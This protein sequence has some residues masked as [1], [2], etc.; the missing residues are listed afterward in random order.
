MSYGFSVRK[1]RE[2]TL[3]LVDHNNDNFAQVAKHIPDGALFSIHGHTPAVGNSPVGMIGV[4]LSVPADES[5]EAMREFVGS[6][7]GQYTVA[8]LK[9]ED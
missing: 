7:S 1:T 4:N 6:A 8:P 5:P 3:E 9:A 2:G